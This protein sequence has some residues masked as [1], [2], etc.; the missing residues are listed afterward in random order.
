MSNIQILVVD[1][2]PDILH[3]LS[4]TLTR[5][6]LKVFTAATI[7]EAKV[8]LDK[9]TF[10]FCLTDMN[11]P[12]GNG[13]ELVEYVNERY[14]N[15]PIA[16]IT[17]YGTISHAVEALK[18]GA[19][20]FITKPISLQVL[21]N[22][23]ANAI[24][25]SNEPESSE[26]ST[27]ERTQLIGSSDYV[28]EMNKKIRKL[29]RSQSSILISGA[30]GTS[31]KTIAK[32]IHF[33]SHRKSKEF[34]S[35]DCI[36]DSREVSDMFGDSEGNNLLIKANGSTLFLENIDSLNMEVQNK[37]LHILTSKK[38][39]LENSDSLD[40][41]I[42]FICTS[43]APLSQKVEMGEFKQGLYERLCVITLNTLM[44]AEHK[45]DIPS[46]SK[47]ILLDYSEQWEQ[48]PCKIDSEALH[49]LCQHT[50]PGN[51]LE[52]KTTLERAANLCENNIIRE[53]DLGFD[54]EQ[55]P[56]IVSQRQDKNLEEYI[57]EIEVQ[58]IKKALE[59]T[60]NNKTAA[61]KILGISFRALRYRIKKLGID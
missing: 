52:L 6:G 16:V 14:R 26:T 34:I 17:A 31:K 53:T 36:E 29:S 24:K 20:D 56:A 1:D 41:D 9:T 47:S 59:L 5:M 2:E 57:E 46:L 32:C 60:N 40:L 8:E 3:L 11:L 61:A 30:R 38:I 42:R 45:E 35:F 23:V 37:L 4:I 48:L 43:A 51:I 21:R 50:F 19:F 18:K 39:S 25:T 54:E 12:D 7:G 44:L 22:L 58:E 27:Q 55:Q 15:T 28:Q 13:L 10:N 49:T 33:S